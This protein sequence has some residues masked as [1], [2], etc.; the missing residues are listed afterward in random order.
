M[1]LPPG[2]QI[3]ADLAA[4]TWELHQ[5]RG[6]KVEDKAEIKK[7]LGRSPDDGDA[8]VMCLSEGAKAAAKMAREDM[9]G[10]RQTRAGVGHAAMKA[11]STV[12]GSQGA[13]G[14]HAHL[15]YRGDRQGTAHGMRWRHAPRDR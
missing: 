1:C 10:E 4:P 11:K 15:G 12:L 14:L 3:K 2:A 9:R 5:T 7:R 13:P 8:I 6:I